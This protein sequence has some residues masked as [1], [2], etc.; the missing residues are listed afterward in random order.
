[1][2]ERDVSICLSLYSKRE[3]MRECIRERESMRQRKRMRKHTCV[4]V[5]L[6]FRSRITVR[7]NFMKINLAI[8]GCLKTYKLP[9]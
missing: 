6:Y 4:C 5:C 3:R 1:M 2:H 9:Q 7:N 8:K